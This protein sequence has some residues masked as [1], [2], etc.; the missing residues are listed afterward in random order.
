MEWNSSWYVEIFFWCGK[1]W[2]PQVML[3][4]SLSV[5]HHRIKYENQWHF[6]LV[7]CLWSITWSSRK[8]FTGLWA[9]WRYRE[10][11]LL[12]LMIFPSFSFRIYSQSLISDIYIQ[13]RICQYVISSRVLFLKSRFLIMWQKLWRRNKNY[14]E[15]ENR[16]D[17]CFGR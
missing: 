4:W 11:L 5:P 17:K 15:L 12:A 1:S 9:H 10:T 7:T 3:R 6:F 14:G 2:E 8:K 13:I 16:P